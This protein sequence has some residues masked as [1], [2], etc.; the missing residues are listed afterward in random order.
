MSRTPHDPSPTRTAALLE[1]AGPALTTRIDKALLQQFGPPRS[2][3][4]NTGNGY[5]AEIAEQLDYLIASVRLGLPAVL[6]DYL[7]WRVRAAP[8]MGTD[9]LTRS[10][11]LLEET[12]SEHLDAAACREVIALLRPA[13]RMLAADAGAGERPVPAERPADPSVE[14]LACALIEGD[15]ISARRLIAERHAPHDYLGAATGLLQQALY[16]VGDKWQAREISV[17]DEH[18]ATA[19]ARTLLTERYAN[20]PDAP[21]HGRRAIIAC[22]RGNQHEL[23]ARIVADALDLAGWTVEFLGGETTHDVLLSRIHGSRPDVV[24][25]SVSLL[26]Q[27]PRLEEALSLIETECPDAPFRL[28]AGGS[29]LTRIPGIPEHLGVDGFYPDAR[30]AWEALS[31]PPAGARR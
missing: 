31:A 13:Q 21:R 27:L 20:A 3:A 2:P 9:V 11:A 23:G 6:E 30:A 5:Q 15:L 29:G 17:A 12:M 1:T 8:P 4:G 16:R 7:A 18:V 24:G 14:Q 25:L 22:V 10:L 26:S 28:I 19:L